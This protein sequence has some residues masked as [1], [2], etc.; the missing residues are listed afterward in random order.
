[1]AK[2]KKDKTKVVDGEGQESRQEAVKQGGTA[3]EKNA[4]ADAKEQEKQT[5][6]AER[7]GTAK[8]EKQQNTV[9]ERRKAVQ[10]G[11]ETARKNVKA[12]RKEN[13]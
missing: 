12:E 13:Q 7:D 8:G 10:V 2:S 3:A 1:M 11:R 5:A 6:P 9:S 4:K